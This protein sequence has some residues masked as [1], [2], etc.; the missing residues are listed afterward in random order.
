MYSLMVSE[1]QLICPVE[2]TN[3]ERTAGR[4]RTSY[5]IVSKMQLD[6]IAKGKYFLDEYKNN[7]LVG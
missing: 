7:E 3:N 5:L 1:L 6:K 2:L 4:G